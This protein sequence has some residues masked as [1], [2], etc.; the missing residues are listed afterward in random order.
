MSNKKNK[1]KMKITGLTTETLGNILNCNPRIA[2]ISGDSY[3]NLFTVS[4]ESHCK[5][6]FEKK[7][8]LTGASYPRPIHTD[9]ESQEV[10]FVW[11]TNRNKTWE[12]YF[13]DQPNN[14]SG[15]W[16]TECITRCYAFPIEGGNKYTESHIGCDDVMHVL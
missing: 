2:N 10:L 11:H 16:L 4:I 14:D 7:E 1:K 13:P 8:T 15:R 6:V 9:F 12:R 5:V 3:Y